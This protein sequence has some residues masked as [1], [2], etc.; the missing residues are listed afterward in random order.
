MTEEYI[1]PN[2][3][4]FDQIC[5]IFVGILSLVLEF[6]SVQGISKLVSGRTVDTHLLPVTSHAIVPLAGCQNLT[7]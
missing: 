2:L 4:K 7:K 3:T 6:F 1:S 5:S